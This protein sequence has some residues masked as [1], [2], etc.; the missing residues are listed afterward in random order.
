MKK[1]YFSG[2]Q[3]ILDFWTNLKEGYDYFDKKRLLPTIE[4]ND[5]GKYIFF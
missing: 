4:V 1:D 2:R 3:D 5:E